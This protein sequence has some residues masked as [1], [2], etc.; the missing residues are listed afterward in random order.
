MVKV[1]HIVRQDGQ[2]GGWVDVRFYSEDFQ[3][4]YIIALGH[5]HNESM[6]RVAAKRKLS[7]AWRLSSD[8]EANGAQYDRTEATVIFFCTLVD[9]TD[10]GYMTAFNKAAWLVSY[11]LVEAQCNC[12]GKQT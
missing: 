11:K 2:P 7:V 4:N 1:L 6:V 10:L 5:A 12:D 8:H 9:L 3:L